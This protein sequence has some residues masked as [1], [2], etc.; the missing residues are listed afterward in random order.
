MSGVI[1]CGPIEKH[2]V[3]GH[4]YGGRCPSLAFRLYQIFVETSVLW[5]SPR[6]SIK[7]GEVSGAGPAASSSS[8]R[9]LTDGKWNGSP[10]VHEVRQTDLFA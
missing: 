2:A 1:R 5:A 3:C 8:L 9:D 6:P 7:T 4:R 10:N